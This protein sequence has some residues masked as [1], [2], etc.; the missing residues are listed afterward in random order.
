MHGIP[1]RGLHRDLTF[2]ERHEKTLGMSRSRA[3]Q[4]PLYGRDNDHLAGMVILQVGDSFIA[5]SHAFL[6][7]E[8]TVSD[9]FLSRPRPPHW[10]RQHLLQWSRGFNK[11]GRTVSIT[12]QKRSKG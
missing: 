12:L 11:N 5:G 3:D 1:E 4:Y 2:M 7:D 6:T 10:Q 9:P 8:N